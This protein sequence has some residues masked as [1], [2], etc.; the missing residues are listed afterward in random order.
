MRHSAVLVSSSFRSKLVA[1]LLLLLSSE[2]L[3]QTPPPETAPAAAPPDQGAPLPPSPP[4]PPPEAEKYPRVGRNREIILGKGSWLRFGG[5]LQAWI[6]YVQT[7]TKAGG[8]SLN[9]FNR[10]ARFI[11]A[12]TFFDDLF[13]YVILDAPRIGQAV[14]SGT[15]MA[16]VVNKF[17]TG[18]L[19]QD[20]F[21]EIKLYG[22]Q[23][24]LAGGLMFIPFS[25]HV[26]GSSTT[27]LGIDTAFTGALVP[28]TSGSRDTGFQLKSYL[29]DDHFEIRVGVFSGSRQAANGDNPVAHNAPRVTGFVQYN[30]LDPEKGYVY[31]G[32]NFGKKMVLGV[33][34]GFDFQ[35]NDSP[36]TDAYSAF[37]AVVYGSYPLAGDASK[38]GGDEIAFEAMYQHFDGGGTTG[39]V[40]TLFKQNDVNVDAQYY[41]KDLSLGVFGKFEMQKFDDPNT[42]GDTFWVGGGLKYFV[43][44]AYCNFT[45]AYFRAI[46]PNKPAT[47][48]DTNELTLQLQVYLY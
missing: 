8:Y 22:D 13:I 1:F 38:D 24:L 7:S 15:A 37:N 23:L 2:A 45:L 3:G 30:F 11:A 6:D 42:A 18:A 27:R 21:G 14:Q 35:K 5:Q 48:N 33:S 43:R 9:F 44:E 39:A 40:P 29:L 46:F 41:N 34:A 10:R 19:V 26:L 4:P 20:M 32:Y 28:N 47:R 31:P 36:Q 16:P 25:R 12:A 17:G